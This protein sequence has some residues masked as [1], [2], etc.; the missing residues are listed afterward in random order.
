M[1][2]VLAKFKCSEIGK[3]YNDK[4]T[5]KADT[6]ADTAT[7]YAVTGPGNEEWSKYTPNGNM[8]L[9]VTNPNIKDFFQVGEEYTL[10]IM[11]AGEE[12][13]VTP[14]QDVPA[15]SNLPFTLDK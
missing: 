2:K 14:I 5:E 3:A 9:Y 15:K 6:I 11:R 13:V 7:F 12:D 8:K 1:R 10:V 4:A